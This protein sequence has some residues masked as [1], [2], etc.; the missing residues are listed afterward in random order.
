MWPSLKFVRKAAACLLA[1]LITAVSY[2]GVFNQLIVRMDNINLSAMPGMPVTARVYVKR[3]IADAAL[4]DFTA[5]VEPAV[6]QLIQRDN[7]LFIESL[8][9]TN[10]GRVKLIVSAQGQSTTNWINFVL[11]PQDLDLD[12]YPDILKLPATMQAQ[13]RD[14]FCMIAESQYFSPSDVWFD[15]H[16]DCGGLIE[17]SFRE[18]L[19][20]HDST[21]AK[22]Y[23]YLTD[24]NIPDT[25][26]YY[27]PDLPFLGSRIFRVREGFFDPD[28]VEKDFAATARGTVLRGHSMNYIGRDLRL[29]EKGDILFYFH[30]DNLKMPSHSMIYLGGPG[31]DPVKGFLLYHTGPSETNKGFMKKIMVYDLLKHPDPGWRPLDENLDFTGIY[32]WKFLD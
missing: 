23:R 10:R 27:Y 17:F 25:R 11:P 26:F 18:A 7:V 28:T 12:G 32:R 29:L 14:W 31:K 1:V 15:V 19:K 8:S 5:A 4:N 30:E 6:V 2:A 20:K 16:K 22:N 21:W 13:F 24:A 9:L 3:L